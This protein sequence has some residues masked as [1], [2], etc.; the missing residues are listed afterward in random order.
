MLFL[1]DIPIDYGKITWKSFH[2]GLKSL[3]QA[4]SFLEV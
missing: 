1:Q 4:G 3:L 2:P